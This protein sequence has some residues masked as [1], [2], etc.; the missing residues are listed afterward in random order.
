MKDQT[1]IKES[2]EKV[3]V[4]EEKEDNEGEAEKDPEESNEN[5]DKAKVLDDMLEKEKTS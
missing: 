4:D 1:D 2:E 5:E 3:I